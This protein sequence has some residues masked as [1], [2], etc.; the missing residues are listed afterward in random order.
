MNNEN[1]TTNEVRD[2]FAD[3]YVAEHGFGWHEN[4]FEEA[5]QDARDKFDGWLAEVRREAGEIAFDE[6]G[7]PGLNPYRKEFK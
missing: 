2:A 5:Y 1:P 6:S 4:D 7:A 3:D